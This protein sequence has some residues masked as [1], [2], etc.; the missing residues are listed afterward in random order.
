MNGLFPE[1]V[2]CGAFDIYL[3]TGAGQRNLHRGVEAVSQC[4]D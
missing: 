3:L 4:S 1:D 2:V